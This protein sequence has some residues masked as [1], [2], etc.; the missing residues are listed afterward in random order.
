M[1]D[2]P[3]PDENA[4]DEAKPSITGS[5][6]NAAKKAHA[7]VENAGKITETFGNAISAVKWIAIAVTMGFIFSFG[8]LAY[9][10]ISAPVKAAAN[11][12]ESVTGAVKAGASS[13]ADG[14]TNILHRLHIQSQNQ[15]RTDKLA[16]TAFKRLANLPEAAPESL[17]ARAFWATN[18]PGHENRVCQLTLEFG[19]G[20]IPVLIAADNKAHAS[21]KSLGSKKDRLMRIIIR[22]DGDD[23]PLRVEWDDESQHWLMKWRATSMTKP[24]EDQVAAQR[25][26]DILAA[27]KSC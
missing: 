4:P 17:A 25:I 24:L 1:T 14:T 3:P 6:I 7:S 13:V 12:T 9:K 8:W 26:H 18:F 11:A 20:D 21:A 16:E 27:T 2:T 23:M 15:K 19:A 5:A 22:A 10:T